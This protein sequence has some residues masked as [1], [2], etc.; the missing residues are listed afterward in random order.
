MFDGVSLFIGALLDALIGPNLFIPGEPF[1][2]AAGYQLHGG[3]WTSTLYVV[4]GAL[5]GDHLSFFIGR[6]WGV[7]SQRR[8]MKWQPKTGRMIARC[9]LLMSRN[10]VSVLAFSRLLG[11]VA[12]VVPFIAGSHNVSWRRFSVYGSVGLLLGIGQF[13]VWGYLLAVGINQLPFVDSLH[14]F[15]LE[16]QYSL[17]VIAMTGCLLVVG[18]KKGWK[19]MITKSAA[20]FL[21]GT[22]V[23]NYG[24]FFW[25]ADDHKALPQAERRVEISSLT[26]INYDV[27]PGKSSY[28]DAQAINVIYLGQNPASLMHELEWIENK[29][30]SQNDLEWGDYINLLRDSTPPVSDLFWQGAPQQLAFQ[31]PGTL[32]K[33][34]H[35]RWWKAGIDVHTQQPIWLGAIS[36]DNGFTVVPYSGFVTVLHSIEPEIDTQRDQLASSVNAL[37]NWQTSL[38]PLSQPTVLDDHHDYFSDGKVLIVQPSISNTL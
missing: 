8:L 16:H 32:S 19:F 6:Y 4:L 10:S 37:Q 5:I 18:W 15:W 2:I 1:F 29:T 30:F 20:L 9:R 27:Y 28:Y 38:Q 7:T 21:I 12:W 13:V 17:L 33:R 11:P 22:C 36:Y 34:N 35:I 14:T 3:I 25:W 24:Y 31:R 26:E 23:I